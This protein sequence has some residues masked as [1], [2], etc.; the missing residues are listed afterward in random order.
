[1]LAKDSASGKH[2]NTKFKTYFQRIGKSPT[3]KDLDETI[4]DILSNSLSSFPN[5]HIIQ[6]I[7][8]ILCTVGGP[9]E[10][11]LFRT[12][13]SYL[14][15]N[16]QKSPNCQLESTPSYLAPV[17]RGSG[18]YQRGSIRPQKTV[19]FGIQLFRSLESP[20]T[21]TTGPETV[22]HGSDRVRQNNEKGYFA[23]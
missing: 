12:F 21:H 9:S 22:A 17:G 23:T 19:S 2:R 16:A 7:Q 11:T 4:K 14:S 10:R 3:L 20:K 15:P 13:S 18:T 6:L 8:Q 1:M 5:P